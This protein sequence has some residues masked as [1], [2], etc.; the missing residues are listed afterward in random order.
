M[1][2]LNTALKLEHRLNLLQRF[3]TRQELPRLQS[4]TRKILSS[5]RTRS[6]WLLKVVDN[7]FR[8]FLLKKKKK[9]LQKAQRV[10]KKN[11]FS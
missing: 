10:K 7:A 6:S 1:L 9:G 3:E 11:F 8:H 5:T 4:S 2:S